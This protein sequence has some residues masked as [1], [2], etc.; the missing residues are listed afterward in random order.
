M[1]ENWKERGQQHRIRKLP[2][3]KCYL[4]LVELYQIDFHSQIGM[5]EDTAALQ[6]GIVPET[7]GAVLKDK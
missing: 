7:L 6:L 1:L 3:V 5:S 2:K 4:Q